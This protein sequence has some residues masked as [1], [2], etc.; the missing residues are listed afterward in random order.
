MENKQEITAVIPKPITREKDN[1]VV[2]WLTLKDIFVLLGTVFSVSPIWISLLA[3]NNQIAGIVIICL[4]A[5][6]GF[7]LVVSL[8]GNRRVYHWVYYL[9]KFLFQPKQIEKNPIEKNEKGHFVLGDK[10]VFT[11]YQVDGVDTSLMEDEQRIAI[12]NR[13]QYLYFNIHSG[14]RFDLLKTK[15]KFELKQLDKKSKNEN[16]Q[17]LIDDENELVQ[18]FNKHQQKEIMTMIIHSTSSEELERYIEDIKRNLFGTMVEISKLP[19][20]YENQIMEDIYLANKKIDIRTDHFVIDEK[21]YKIIAIEK[22]PSLVGTEWNND[23]FK[24]HQEIMICKN[25]GFSFKDSKKMV[26]KAI[27]AAEYEVSRD[28]HSR[29]QMAEDLVVYQNLSQQVTKIATSQDS[30]VNCSY[31]LMIKANDKKELDAKYKHLSANYFAMGV[32]IDSLLFR[33]REAI[34]SITTLDNLLQKSISVDALSSTMG[35][36]FPLEETI[37][38]DENCFIFGKTEFDQPVTIDWK[39][40]DESKNMSNACFIGVSGSGKT[41]SCKKMIKNQIAEGDYICYAVDPENEYTDLFKQL[42]GN[43]IGSKEAKINMFQYIQHHF[44][45]GKEIVKNNISEKIDM[46]DKIFSILLGRLWDEVNKAIILKACYELYE[47][48]KYK[49]GNVIEFTFTDLYKHLIKNSSTD[50][51]KLLKAIELYTKGNAYGDM[52]DYLSDFDLTN[53]HTCFNMQDVTSSTTSVVQQVKT[54]LLLNFLEEKVISNRLMGNEK[55]ISI[56]VD[57]GHLFINN[58]NHSLIKFFD[59]WFRRIRKYNGMVSFVTQ[60]LI[61]LQNNNEYAKYTKSI[62]NNSHYLLILNVKKEDKD[63][64]HS[65]MIDKGGLTP[66]ERMYLSECKNGK[67]ILFEK[68]HRTK[69]QVLM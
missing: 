58:E 30:L 43:V 69:L 2:L 8:G 39:K 57:E 59:A 31:F 32:S 37:L 27:I 15:S 51:K 56:V 5:L 22:L 9:F 35:M 67:G 13:L 50:D 63:V 21:Y 25:I 6:I 36:G 33:Q 64:L 10:N 1:K 62:F 53:E 65:L 40:K 11:I 55:Y 38:Q 68:N 46:L 4:A 52:F 3:T 61:D 14:N 60:N 42:G 19:E 47:N 54:I 23:L 66:E 26:D 41:T 17:K 34:L 20:K 18:E 48:K 12:Y 45:I 44:Q 16:I 49:K 29:N 24:S 28:K 7:G